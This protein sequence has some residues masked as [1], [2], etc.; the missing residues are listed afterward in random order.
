MWGSNS[1][2]LREKLGILSSLPLVG[3]TQHQGW[4]VYGET[5]SQ[6]LLPISGQAFL[7]FTRY[8]AVAQLVFEFFAEDIFHM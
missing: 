4:G 8:V 6:P 2:L 7:L 5:V 3:H 1:L